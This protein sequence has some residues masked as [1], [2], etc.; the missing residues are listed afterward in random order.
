MKKF[1]Y[2]FSLLFFIL[3]NNEIH[4][5]NIATKLMDLNGGPNAML[6][7]KNIMYIG[8]YNQDK[9]VKI[10]LFDL[11]LPPVTVVENILRPYGFALKDNI[12]YISE[13]NGNRIRKKNLSSPGTDSEILVN[14][15]TFPIGL[16]FL[17]NDLY[18][19]SSGSDQIFKFDV[20]QPSSLPIVVT[21][22]KKPFDI[23]IIGNEIYYTE[24]ILGR[25][26]KMNLDIPGSNTL[27]HQ[28]STYSYPSGL[29]SRNN[30]LYVAIPEENNI[31]KINLNQSPPNVSVT[32]TSPLFSHASRIII[33]NNTMYVGDIFANAI[34][35]GQL[36]TLSTSE[37]SLKNNF[38]IFPN[39][40]KEFVTVK[41]TSEKEYKIFDLSGR[42]I[43]S[44]QISNSRIYCGTLQPGNYILKI[45]EI[46]KK[47]IKQP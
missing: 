22:A 43:Q 41:G 35:T 16:E 31:S 23:E 32:F 38:S 29:A 39:P 19:A 6:I 3:F 27:V 17:N 40:V 28:F 20:S 42:R 2:S 4:A 18:I 45:G 37:V 30:E 14:G 47:L 9:V 1:F 33:N 46:S 11:S 5:Q 21:E 25:V 12:L 7:D 24:R 34:F 13:F 8:L 15:I 26:S 36:D 10:D 44:G